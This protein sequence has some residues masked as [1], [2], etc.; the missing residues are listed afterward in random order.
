MK[1]LY[2]LFGVKQAAGDVGIEIECE[3]ENLFPVTT[4]GWRTEADNSLRGEFPHRS[5][6][7]V[8]AKPLTI[9]D[10]LSAL[11]WLADTQKKN[12]AKFNFSFRTSVH[13]HVNVQKLTTDE[14]LN[15]L[16]TYFICERV[17]MKYCAPHRSGNRFCL[18]LEDAEG[19][20]P[21]LNR[22]VESDP[23]QWIARNPHDRIRYSA[24]NVEALWKYG[25][26]EFR[27]LEGN[28]DVERIHNWASAFVNMREFAKKFE[29]IQDVHDFFVKNSPEAFF[30]A[31]VGGVY[32]SFIYDGYVNDLRRGFSFTID[33]P[34]SYKP[35][36]EAEKKGIYNPYVGI[37]NQQLVVN[38]INNMVEQ[39]RV[40]NPRP[41]VRRADRPIVRF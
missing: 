33:I 19:M 13:V 31:A 41:P 10:A 20:L 40:A 6:E 12:G 16:Y 3:G 25:S 26:L 24:L 30:R 7:W 18:R 9:T 15:M 23:E 29:N 28:M 5:C 2:E 39:L 1:K 8:F 35:R 38:E 21:F 4:N 14:I 36:K 37:V 22:L 27:G 34:Y 32:K 11:Q 17:M